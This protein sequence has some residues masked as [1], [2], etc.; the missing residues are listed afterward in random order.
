MNEE[1]APAWALDE[2]RR[3]G[4]A[5]ELHFRLRNASTIPEAAPEGAHWFRGA[6][7]VLETDD[8]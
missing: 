7:Y 3:L 2:L 5:R 4:S 8:A 6:E 1:E